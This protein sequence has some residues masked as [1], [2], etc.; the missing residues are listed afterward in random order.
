MRAVWA[1][2]G[3]RRAAAS[4]TCGAWN[5]KKNSSKKGPGT[6]AEAAEPGCVHFGEV[7]L[8]AACTHRWSRGPL[9]TLWL[10]CAETRVHI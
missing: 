3:R 10:V 7:L 1:A 9:S 6:H 5:L 2:W 8:G 4:V